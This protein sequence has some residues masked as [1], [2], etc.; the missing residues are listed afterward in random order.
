MH[1]A[2]NGKAVAGR[3]TAET[4][5]RVPGGNRRLCQRISAVH[6]GVKKFG[7]LSHRYTGVCVPKANNGNTSLSSGILEGPLNW[8]SYVYHRAQSTWILGAIESHAAIL[9][10]LLNGNYTYEGQERTP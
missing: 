1:G 6:A 8:Y 2:D 5:E 9:H 3:C 10:V 4:R 7:I